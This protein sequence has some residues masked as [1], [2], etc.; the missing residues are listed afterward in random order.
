LVPP[1]PAPG[2]AGASNPPLGKALPNT[3]S[4]FLR[5]RSPSSSAVLVFAVLVFAVLVFAVLVFAVLVL[6]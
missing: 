5:G 4:R 2:R 1:S 3:S 6:L